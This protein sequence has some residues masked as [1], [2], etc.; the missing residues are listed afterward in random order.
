MDSGTIKYGGEVRLGP[1]LTS[2]PPGF[3]TGEI[4]KEKKGR[5]K[6]GDGEITW[7]GEGNWSIYKAW[8]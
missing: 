2:S 1:Y 8:L 4:K 7:A 6:R 3:P 5:K